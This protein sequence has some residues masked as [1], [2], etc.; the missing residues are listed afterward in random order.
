MNFTF[1]LG[2]G[3]VSGVVKVFPVS[4]LSLVRNRPGTTRLDDEMGSQIGRVTSHRGKDPYLYR[5]TNREERSRDQFEIPFRRR[6]ASFLVD[7]LANERELTRKT[8]TTSLASPNPNIL[9]EIHFPVKFPLKYNSGC[10][11]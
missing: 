8:F 7:F 3:L 1:M 6:A 4:S 9:C 11:V 2:F 10:L 5:H